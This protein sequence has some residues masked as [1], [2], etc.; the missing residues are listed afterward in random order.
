M[1]AF[2]TPC[3]S[4]LAAGGRRRN[5]HSRTRSVWILGTGFELCPAACSDTF[6]SDCCPGWRADGSSSGTDGTRKANDRGACVLS[7]VKPLRRQSPTVH[8]LG[9]PVLQTLAHPHTH[10]PVPDCNRLPFS[11]GVPLPTLFIVKIYISLIC[12]SVCTLEHTLRRGHHTNT[13]TLITGTVSKK[14]RGKHGDLRRLVPPPPPPPPI[15]KYRRSF[16]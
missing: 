13:D 10:S 7:G 9:A 5:H 12:A 14:T 15:N 6:I 1:S 3:S 2:A 8:P 16:S 11:A 4:E